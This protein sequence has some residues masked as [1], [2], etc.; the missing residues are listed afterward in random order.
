MSTTGLDVFDHTLHTTNTWLDEIS[1]RIGPDRKLAWKVLTTVLQTVRDMLQPDLAAH[2]AAE[3]PLLVRGGY[4]GHYEPSGQPRDIAGEDAFLAVIAE[5]LAE[6]RG[7]DP[8]DAAW[9]VFS[10]LDR[11]VSAGEVEKV[12]HALRGDIRALW[13]ATGEAIA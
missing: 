11:H 8:K 9:A 6:S 13:P 12:R 2:L 3:L 5:G 4:Y 1:G 10:V 7:V